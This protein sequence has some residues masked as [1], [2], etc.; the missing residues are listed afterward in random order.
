MQFYIASWCVAVHRVERP[1]YQIR[2]WGY[3]AGQAE[4]A[5][6]YMCSWKFS[7][8]RSLAV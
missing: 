2:Q 3:V 4:T 1:P 6:V 5:A 7:K 8:V